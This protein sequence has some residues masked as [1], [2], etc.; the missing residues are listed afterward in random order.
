MEYKKSPT[1]AVI[2]IGNEILSGQTQDLNINYIAEKLFEKGI[3]LLEAR[4]IIDDIEVIVRA[5]NECRKKYTYVFTTGGIGPTHDDVTTMAIAKVF[6][7]QVQRDTKAK[8][9]LLEKYPRSLPYTEERLRMADLPQG[10]HLIQNPI[11]GAP[12]Y[13]IENVYVLAGVPN[14]MQ[15]M[16]DNLL[17]H[18]NRGAQIFRKTIFIPLFESQISRQL[19]NIQNTF[20]DV[21]IGSYPTWHP[22]EKSGTH[23]VVKG[24]DERKLSEVIDKILN[25]PKEIS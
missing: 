18:L 8:K 4:I 19:R 21:E 10:A 9:L 13:F 23:V 1:A 20:P 11:S 17:F 24:H 5:V 2:V 15:S 12:G 25:I 14:I 3:S 22:D 16:F 6:D 7:L